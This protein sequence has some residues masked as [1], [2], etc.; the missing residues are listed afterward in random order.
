MI[1]DRSQYL[2]VTIPSRIKIDGGIMPLRPDGYHGEDDDGQSTDGKLILRGED[3]AWVMEWYGRMGAV[4][5]WSGYH[6]DPHYLYPAP[7]TTYYK[8]A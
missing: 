4:T 1:T 7:D 8:Y 5:G 3:Q 2:C 6:I